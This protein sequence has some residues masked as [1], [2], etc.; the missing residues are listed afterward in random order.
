MDMAPGGI[1]LF[2][3]EKVDNYLLYTLMCSLLLDSYLHPATSWRLAF[4]TSIGFVMFN[5]GA[6]YSDATIVN[7]FW[8][9]LAYP[10]SL[11]ARDAA[12]CCWICLST[13]IAI[14]ISA[15]LAGFIP[16]RAQF[17][18]GVYRHSLG[19]TWP[20]NLSWYTT[21]AVVAWCYTKA[22][23]WRLRHTAASLV[24]LVLAYVIGNGRVAFALG[25]F[26][27]ALLTI[28]SCVRDGLRLRSFLHHAAFRLAIV[29][30]W[31]FEFFF[32]TM[33]S[34]CARFPESTIARVAFS[35]LGS[36]MHEMTTC[37]NRYGYGLLG[38]EVELISYRR[39][40]ATGEEWFNVDNSYILH[41]VKYG[42]LFAAIAL[43]FVV[44]FIRVLEKK[45]NF[46]MAVIV[47]A[48]AICGA[49]EN[50]ILLPVFNFAIIGFAQT[51]SC[52]EL[53]YAMSP[54]KPV[55]NE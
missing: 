18:H 40:L 53:A 29:L 52:V 6:R 19:F 45:D 2:L 37:Y 50:L 20:N 27:V 21:S 39:T 16:D 13:M 10:R 25:L 46:A 1:V 17:E 43:V 34:A 48:M 51:I 49:S 41:T 26:V 22:A 28:D 54:N 30:P 3:Y 23:C 8:F 24:P 55:G 33:A 35:L 31:A 47:T 5:V 38:K 32:L 15:H 12:R 9:V 4:G 11:S 14:I 7:L 36:R 42:L 44:L